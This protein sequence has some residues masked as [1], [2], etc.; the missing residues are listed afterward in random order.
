MG[1]YGQGVNKAMD[2]FQKTVAKDARYSNPKFKAAANDFMFQ[3]ANYARAQ[4]EFAVQNNRPLPDV[5]QTLSDDMIDLCMYTAGKHAK[6]PANVQ[7]VKYEGVA[8]GTPKQAPQ[9]KSVRQKSAEERRIQE[10]LGLTDEQ[11]EANE[12]ESEELGL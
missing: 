9:R 4:V 12:H 3:L 2:S 10:R 7:S 11:W 8:T 1:A 5:S 6:I